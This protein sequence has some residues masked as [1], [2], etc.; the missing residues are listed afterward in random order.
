M[1]QIDLRRVNNTE[2]MLTKVKM[3][4]PDMMVCYNFFHMSPNSV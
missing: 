2:I 1:M 4:L 3:P